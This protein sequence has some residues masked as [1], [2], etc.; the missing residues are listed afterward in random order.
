MGA[1]EHHIGRVIFDIPAVDQRTFDRFGSMVRAR[2]DAVK[3]SSL[4]A[5]NG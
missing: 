3:D 1:A 4:A 5:L 2:F